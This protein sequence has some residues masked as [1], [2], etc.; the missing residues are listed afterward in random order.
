MPSNA[1]KKF[2]ENMADV[3]H[4]IDLYGAMEALSEADG[5]PISE[6]IDVLFRSA[7]VLMVSHWEAYVEDICSEALTH[8]VDHLP[9]AESLPKELKLST[10]HFYKSFGDK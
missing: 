6:G 9:S 2:D 1:R 3:D 7:V 5:E 4:L 10:G 8:L